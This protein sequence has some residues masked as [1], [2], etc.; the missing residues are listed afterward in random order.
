M[1]TLEQRQ[2]TLTSHTPPSPAMQPHPRETLMRLRNLAVFPYDRGNRHLHLL[3]GPCNDSSANPFAP[4]PPAFRI[5]LATLLELRIHSPVDTC[6]QFI[7]G[8][9]LAD[10]LEP[11]H[12]CRNWDDLAPHVL[13]AQQYA[14]A[15]P[16]RSVSPRL[17]P[18][19]VRSLPPPGSPLTAT[20]DL[21]VGSMLGLRPGPDLD[22][23]I[24]RDL[25][26][27]GSAYLHSWLAVHIRHADP[28][29]PDNLFSATERRH[30]AFGNN[31]ATPGW[32][33]ADH[34]FQALPGTRITDPNTNTSPPATASDW[35]ITPLPAQRDS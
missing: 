3:A 23:S 25:A 10:I 1:H 32:P 17:T 22:H 2:Q 12:P 5:L 27:L 9:A 21:A 19:H 6:H 13:S 31:T 4:A 11:L 20:A 34:V 33:P 8:T 26:N 7:A 29:G 18:F 30:Y 24:L 14:I 35:R 28:A 16:D 15:G